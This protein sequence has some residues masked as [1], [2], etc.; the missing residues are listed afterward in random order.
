M[1]STI[2]GVSTLCNSSTGSLLIQIPA[3][4]AF[5]ELEAL[6]QGMGMEGDIKECGLIVVHA[7]QSSGKD[8]VWHVKWPIRKPHTLS[9]TMCPLPTMTMIIAIKYAKLNRKS[10]ILKGREHFRLISN[11]LQ[12][13]ICVVRQTPHLWS[14]PSKDGSPRS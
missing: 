3:V 10:H 9:P 6:V 5:K 7:A 13:H 1:V 12:L 2:L 11:I 8:H 4:A 14:R